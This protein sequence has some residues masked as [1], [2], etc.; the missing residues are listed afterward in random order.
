[1]RIAEHR[2]TVLEGPAGYGKTTLAT[3]WADDLAAR[4]H[5]VGWLSLDGEDHQVEDVQRYLFAAVAQAFDPLDMEGLDG[6]PASMIELINTLSQAARP[7]VLFIDDCH[8]IADDILVGALNRLLQRAPGSTHLVLCSRSVIPAALKQNLYLDDLLQLGANEL[9]FELDETRDLLRKTGAESSLELAEL[10]RYTEGWV[11]GLRACL[12]APGSAGSIH[13]A[14]MRCVRHVF[15]E[16]LQ[17]LPAGQRRAVLPLG[18]LDKFSDAML[19][20]VLGEH[21]AF[22]LIDAL[23][24][25]SVFIQPL[26]DSRAWYCLHPMFREYLKTR[27][28]RR[29]GED[30]NRFLLTAAE[31]CAKHE[32]WLDAIRL[33]MEGGHLDAVRG[34]IEGCAMELLEQG[35]F[36]TLVALEKRWQT[37]SSGAPLALKIARAW[38]LGVALEPE[39]A[40][41]MMAEIAADIAP[42]GEQGAWIDWEMRS[43]DAMLAGLADQNHISGPLA[44]RC[45]RSPTLRPWVRNVL[46]NLISCSHFHAGRWD[47]FYTVPPTLC[48]P[49]MPAGMLFHDCYRQSLHALAQSMQ[50]RLKDGINDLTEFLQRVSGRFADMPDRPNPALVALPQAVI[51]QLQYLLGNQAAAQACLAQGTDLV[52][53]AGFLDCTAAAY[54]TSARLAWHQGQHQRARRLLEQLEGLAN[55]HDWDRLR[56]RVLLERSRIN[57][58]DGK[59]REAAACV[60]GLAELARRYPDAHSWEFEVYATLSALWLAMHR[61]D[62][63]AELIARAQALTLELQARELRLWHAELGLAL[64]LVEHLNQR[65]GRDSALLE[66]VLL[67]IEQSGAL[68]IVFDCPLG[69]QDLR[70]QE[71]LAP[72]VWQP[73]RKIRADA[74]V[75]IHHDER[76]AAA[77]LDL[78]VKERQVMQLVAEGKSNKQ[79]ARD[80]NV[81]PETIKSHMKSIFAKLKVDNRAQAAVMLRQ[82]G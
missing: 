63:D 45:Y 67:D 33:G 48:G 2:L 39:S 17:Y 34:W 69:N 24:D 82:G 37:H 1:V 58:L 74:G 42:M 9:R 14:T 7:L 26:D 21:A 80:L 53:M 19:R 30:A 36:A 73:I 65:S 15:D 41:A 50:G 51:A 16:A 43:L 22:G 75:G 25:Q 68:A 66:Q 3:I 49:G 6:Q 55:I 62:P 79:I 81:A 8:R 13:G 35:D 4:G 57:L 38:A 52:D 71:S 29:N 47:A 5:A 32:R 59:Y 46:L 78:T 31:W 28:L 56:A 44:E 70:C 76:Q 12:Q 72:S 64:G 11:T 60:S 18:M 23:L 77:L 54:C 40:R 61:T 20:N 27:Y 10:Q